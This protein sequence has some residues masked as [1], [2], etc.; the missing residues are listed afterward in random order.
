MALPPVAAPALEE[1]PVGDMPTDDMAMEE[2]G[3]TVLL[4]VL[5]KPDGTFILERGAPMDA[6]PVEGEG[7]ID[8][9]AEPVMEEAAGEEFPEIGP[10]MKAILDTIND[11]DG[12]GEGAFD[13]GFNDSG[14]PTP[15]APAAG[16]AQKY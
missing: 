16:N 14:A 15:A 12:G 1:P 8:A 5:V 4:T 7:L 9:G 10:L 6:M 11:A 3:P 2:A 13:A